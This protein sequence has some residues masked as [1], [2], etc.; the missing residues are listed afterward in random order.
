MSCEDLMFLWQA[1]FLLLQAM[2]T[3]ILVGP[4]FSRGF[5]RWPVGVQKSTTAGR[6][7]SD[8]WLVRSPGGG[9][10]HSLLVFLPGKS[11]MHREAWV[12]YNY[13]GRKVSRTP[14][15]GWAGTQCPSTGLACVPALNAAAQ[16]P[17]NWSWPSR[18]PFWTVAPQSVTKAL[19]FSGAS[20]RW[21]C[22]PTTP[23]FSTCYMEMSF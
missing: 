16:N 10:G 20:R 2:A 14:L 12:S 5:P 1:F 8:P 21:C 3:S 13:G 7:R 4:F 22:T 11:Y 18:D 6:R 17:S 23:L 9:N 15:S 19:S